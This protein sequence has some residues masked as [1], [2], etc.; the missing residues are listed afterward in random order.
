MSLFFM[1]THQYQQM[2]HLYSAEYEVTFCFTPV[3][4]FNSKDNGKEG[5]AILRPILMYFNI[6]LS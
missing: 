3:L 2:A 4:T 1:Q 5:K 6:Q